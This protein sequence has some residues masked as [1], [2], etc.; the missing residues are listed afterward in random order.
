M[1]NI[2]EDTEA[3]EKQAINPNPR[4]VVQLNPFGGGGDGGGENDDKLFEALF[5][6]DDNDPDFSGFSL[7]EEDF[8]TPSS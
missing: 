5:G 8:W 1:E 6:G 4:A 2:L 3:V 7:S